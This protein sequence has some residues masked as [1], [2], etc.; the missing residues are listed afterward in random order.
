[1]SS[2]FVF[3]LYYSPQKWISLMYLKYR[4]LNKMYYISTWIFPWNY[5]QLIDLLHYSVALCSN[6][7]VVE[8]LNMFHASSYSIHLNISLQGNLIFRSINNLLFK[9]TCIISFMWRILLTFCY[10]PWLIF[11]AWKHC[12]NT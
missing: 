2:S 5:Q 6:S 9:N 10:W 7:Y 12:I 3:C 11:V 1:M 4:K 8:A